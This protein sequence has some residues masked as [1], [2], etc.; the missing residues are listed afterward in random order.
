MTTLTAPTPPATPHIDTASS[1]DRGLLSGVGILLAGATG[2]QI[3]AAIGALAYPVLGPAGVVAVRQIVAGAVLLPIAR[4]DVRRMGWHQWWPVLVLAGV[5]S[6]MN[7]ALYTSISR[8]GLGLA[9]TLEFIGPLAVA[10]AS[11][12]RPRDFVVALTALLGVYVLVLP[13]ATT[14]VL[15]VALALTAAA[16]WAAYIL[17]NRILGARFHGIEG[18]ALASGIAA[19]LY[20]PVLI[21]TL[22][23]VN[24]TWLA[25]AA[26]ACTGLLASVVPYAIDVIVLRRVPQR[27]FSVLMSMHP[28]LAAVAGLVV[29]QQGLSPHELIGMAIVIGANI[30][31]VRS[32]PRGTLL[33]RRPLPAPATPRPQRRRRGASLQ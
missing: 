33:R 2:N 3:G 6:I 28:A 21:R 1:V 19:V 8:I 12:R 15:G 13:N 17:L 29:L 16:C 10:L 5:L 20:L 9:V 27:T 23:T 31:A 7:L 14:D 26:A 30:A 25:L 4:P 11:S 22:L 18:P 32:G 24:V